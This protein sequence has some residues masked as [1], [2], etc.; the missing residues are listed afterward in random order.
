MRIA[1]LY[2]STTGKTRAAAEVLGREFA[3]ADLWNVADARPE[4][5]APYGAVLFGTSTWGTGLLQDDW[6]ARVD[7][8]PPEC[9]E[10]KVVAFFGLGDR[11]V[12]PDTFCSGVALLEARF[13]PRAAR[14]VGPALLLDDDNDPG[15]TQGLLR[16]WAARIKGS[17]VGNR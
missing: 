12:F 1:I 13:A 9:V 8:F 15:R 6:A 11:I 4:D 7:S 5:L 3:E 10:N 16:A 14:V 2:G 17:G